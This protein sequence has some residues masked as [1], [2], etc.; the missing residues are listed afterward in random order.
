MSITIK[1]TSLSSAKPAAVSR[2]AAPAAAPRRD[3]RWSGWL[4]ALPH[5]LLFLVFL[6]AP[7]LFGLYLSLHN[8]HVL[9]K[10]HPFVGLANYQSALS[11]DIFW[12]ALRNTAYFVILAVPA[13]NLVSLLLALGL[14]GV[15]RFATFYKVAFYLPVVISIAV[16]AVLWQWLFNT[17]VGLLNLYLD[18]AVTGLRHLG[19][20]LAPFEPIPWL[21]N[22]HMAMPSIALMSIWWGAG[23]NMILYLA[24]INNIAPDYY[25]AATIDG[26]NGWQRFWA[27]TWPLLKPTTLFC[28]V[29]SVLGAFQVFG[30]SYVLYGGASGPGRAA[31]TMVLYMYQQGFSQYEIGYGAAIAYLLFAVVLM[32]TGIQ[33]WLFSGRKAK[34]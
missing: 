30:Q 15:K 8:W 3:D 1:S 7:T 4:F 22:P 31:L 21:S 25:E 28:L 11:D 32:L 24:G 17:Q 6:L 27:I 29:F 19:L 16:V 13:G 5:F 14:A 9:A 33:F 23:G 12:L 34:D 18:A 20:P 2:A 26:A 10:H